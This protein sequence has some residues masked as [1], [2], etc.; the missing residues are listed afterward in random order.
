M[1]TQVRIDGE[2]SVIVPVHNGESTIAVCIEALLAQTRLPA[3][4]VIVDNNSR[5]KTC[6]I[7]NQY[8]VTLLHENIQTSYAARNKGLKHVRTEYVALL[9]ADC[10]AEPCW[11]E[12]LIKPFESE[13]ILAVAGLIADFPSTTIAGEFMVQLSPFQHR[14]DDRPPVLLTGNVAYR[15]EVIAS[16][17]WFDEA[18]PTAG[19]VDLGWR[20]RAFYGGRI[21]RAPDAV[22]QHKHRTTWKGLFRQYKRYGLSEILL[23]T[24]Y[25][26][27]SSDAVLPKEQ[28]RRMLRQI[29]AL[30][31]YILSFGWR[32]L[33]YPFG[34]RSRDWLFWPLLWLTI[35]SASLSG[36]LEGLALTRWFRRNPYRSRP[37]IRRCPEE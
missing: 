22:V 31:V 11:L 10:I 3:E 19:D 1:S 32:L 33:R 30:F 34:K 9:D 37:E 13:D 26:N 36:K 5:D 14:K 24:L 35:E 25:R 4:I 28:A 18:L 27:C 2:V 21:A 20:L 15:H 16:L 7:V 23:T 8:P 6:E 12:R 29:R 17:G